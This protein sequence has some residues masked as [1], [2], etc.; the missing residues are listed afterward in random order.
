MKLCRLSLALLLGMALAALLAPWPLRAQGG[1]QIVVIHTATAPQRDG[2]GVQVYFALRDADGA[3]LLQDAARLEQAGLM[4]LL[5]AGDQPVEAVVGAPRTPIKVLMLMD[6]SGS[7]RPIIGEVRA[8]AQKAVGAAP[9]TAL[10]GVAQFAQLGPADPLGMIQPFT[11]N[12]RLASQAIEAIDPQPRA[13]TCL[14]NASF[15]AIE[16][17]RAAEDAPQERQAIIIFTDGK[18]DNGSNAPCSS[19]SVENVITGARE[20]G[21]P[22]YTIGLCE[23]AACG[24]LEGD[25]LRAMAAD[26][27][28]VSALGQ[29]DDLE[30]LFQLIMDGLGSQWVA[31]AL[32]YPRD[33]LNRGALSVRLGADG[34]LLSQTF[35]FISDA[36]Y[37][38]PATFQ[39]TPEYDEAQDRYNLGVQVSNPTTLEEVTLEVWGNEGLVSTQSYAPGDLAAPVVVPTERMLADTNYCFRVKA[40]GRGGVALEGPK[41]EPTLAEVCVDYRPRLSFTITSADP[42]W[43]NNRLRIAVS[44]RGAGSQTPLFEGRITDKGGQTIATV[45]RVAPNDEGNLVIDLPPAFRQVAA[46]SEFQ[47]ALTLADGGNVIDQK[48]S[49]TITPPRKPWPW[50]LIIG[51]GV[52]LLFAIGLA[53]LL[54]NRRPRGAR[55]LPAPAAVIFNDPTRELGGAATTAAAQPPARQAPRGLRLRL[56]IT[57]TTDAEQRGKALVLTQENLPYVIGR[58]AS[59]QLT[60]NDREMS[61]SHTQLAVAG[62]DLFITDLNSLNGTFVNGQRL[63]AN[64]RQPL[65]LPAELRLGHNTIVVVEQA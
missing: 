15:Q 61:K 11:D 13:P 44:V 45:Q 56:T 31:E 63:I 64:D 33:G 48:Y 12:R 60:I 9:E 7:M 5:G 26:T 8:A 58:S 41:G 21:I 40:T 53:T 35:D 42:D 18:D 22:L 59:A 62:R 14:Y 2:L 54:L 27:G 10:L 52:S 47:I 30:D 17:L 37:N 57:Q 49:I 46:G 55:G 25:V 4:E 36:D 24:N 1:A 20:R 50:G 51:A 19:R 39:L 3:P 28:G 23:D 38:A 6:A 16:T 43:E 65:T 32:L 34:P 29:R